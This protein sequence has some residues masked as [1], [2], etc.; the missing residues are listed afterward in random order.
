MEDMKYF[1]EYGEFMNKYEEEEE[2]AT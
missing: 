2:W 1:L